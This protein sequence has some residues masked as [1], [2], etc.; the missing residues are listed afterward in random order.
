MF[1]AVLLQVTAHHVIHS[2]NL[3]VFPHSYFKSYATRI[4]HCIEAVGH[5]TQ[6][7]CYTIVL[8]IAVNKHLES[9]ISKLESR[10]A[11]DIDTENVQSVTFI[12]IQFWEIFTLNP[13]ILLLNFMIIGSFF[14][15]FFTF[16]ILYTI[17]NTNIQCIMC[18]IKYSMFHRVECRVKLFSVKKVVVVLVFL[19]CNF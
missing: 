19:T 9:G 16:C 18:C 2:S 11:N 17:P 6:D 1:C 10:F 3:L 5:K 8:C 15:S 4:I 12:L 13:C 7:I 14:I